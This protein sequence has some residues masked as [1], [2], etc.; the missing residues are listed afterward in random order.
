[1]LCAGVLA[2]AA[3]PQ[4]AAPSGDRAPVVAFEERGL[5]LLDA[6]RLTLANDPL[7]R[8]REAQSAYKEGVAQEAT[9][10][11]DAVLS[12]EASYQYSQEELRDSTKREEQKNRDDLRAAIPV[13][14]EMV[15]SLGRAITNISNPSLIGNSRSVDL[16]AGVTYR[17]IRDEMSVLQS[18]LALIDDMIKST[19]DP[20]VRNDLVLLRQQ[21]IETAKYRFEQQYGEIKNEPA[22]LQQM[23]DDL[24]ATPENQFSRAVKLQA[25]LTKQY[26]SGITFAPYV[27]LSY[28]AANYVGKTSTDPAKGGL[29]VKDLYQGEVGFDLVLPLLRGRGRTSVAATEMAAKDDLEASRLEVLHQ[30]TQSVLTT[31]LAYW[32]LKSAMEQVEVL[33][34][35]VRL[36]GDLLTLTRALIK[37][38][39]LPRA[40]ESR[41][42]AGYAD[43]Q[44]RL[45]AAE[46]R[47]SDARV[48]L[49]RDLGVAGEN[50]AAL[51]MA[52]DTFPQPPDKLAAEDD[53]LNALIKDA[54]QKRFDHQA[55]LKLQ[56]ASQRLALGAKQ[57]TRRK[58]DLD[59]R[60]WSNTLGEESPKLGS[61]DFLS[62]SATLSLEVPFK[63]NQLKG[64][65][66]Q[67]EA[68]LKQSGID[69]QDLARTIGLNVVRLAQS[70]RLS[71]ARLKR[72][73]EAVRF[74]DRTI[75]DENAKLK[76]GDSTLIDMIQTEQ[77]TTAARV[78]KVTAQQ[79]YASLLAQLR[80][81]AG[82][83]IQ[84]AQGRGS[85][86]SDNL[87]QLPAALAGAR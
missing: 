45:S 34:R 12:G 70:L 60:Y 8:L 77:Q 11:F 83:L 21:T 86:T 9:G 15:N 44:A 32:E 4:P 31:V 74:Y 16:S 49:A 46:R 27:D 36:Q 10:Q 71:A 25:N 20:L 54:A 65:L 56:Q 69:A 35:S 55:A 2:Q 51:P 33:K 43:A 52:A 78:A 62:G 67:R 7:I 38:K 3:N 73:E 28:S 40:D 80:S 58:L 17:S 37:A 63:N 13:V 66:A 47:L 82:L 59:L 50:A 29:G 14:T 42:Q 84:D 5:S 87:L 22:H 81:E 39:E 23:L 68:S 85:V 57:D 72:A 76:A 19:A 1:L 79:E 30:K 64:R 41:A 26:R 53:A 61:W 24:G 18:Q 75:D 6:V 48:A